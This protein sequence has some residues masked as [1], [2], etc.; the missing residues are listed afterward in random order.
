MNTSSWPPAATEQAAPAISAADAAREAVHAGRAAALAA[1]RQTVLQA[2]HALGEMLR[3]LAAQ[4]PT[5]TAP[6]AAPMQPSRADAV[7]PL[8]PASISGDTIM[9]DDTQPTPPNQPPA[10][11]AQSPGSSQIEAALKAAQAQIDQAMA[12]SDR[13][14]QA[15]MQAATAATAAAGNTQAVDSANEAL[16][17]ADQAAAAAVAAAQQQT[18]Q[19]MSATSPVNPNPGSETAG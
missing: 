1:A 8:H 13:A 4:R 15:A 14:V 11:T 9:S 5:E 2:E 17:Q 12:A 3:T 10:I 7:T 16:Q 18:E 6:R 19:A